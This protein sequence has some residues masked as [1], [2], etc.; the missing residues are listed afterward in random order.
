MLAQLTLAGKPNTTLAIRRLD[1]GP[2]KLQLES[3]TLHFKF[4]DLIRALFQLN[5]ELLAR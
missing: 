2:A 4:Y 1:F 5:S 3:Q